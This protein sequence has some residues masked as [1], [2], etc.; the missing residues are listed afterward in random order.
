MSFPLSPILADMILQEKEAIGH[1]S[2]KL[3][4]YTVRYVDNILLAV[5]SGKF[6]ITNIFNS[7]HQ[8]LQFTLEVGE[9]NR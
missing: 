4:F 3:P 6:K 1:L 9:R 5:P 7:F 8:R 2:F